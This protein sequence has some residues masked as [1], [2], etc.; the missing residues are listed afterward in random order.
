MGKNLDKLGKI[1]EFQAPWETATGESEVEKPKLRRWI[2]GLLKDKASAQDARDEA[3]EKVKEIETERD[4]VKKE[5]EAKGDP[6]LAKE[7]EKSRGETAKEK[8]R[9]D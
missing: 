2:F 9:A 3:L 1:D 4:E 6:D 8:E 7:L 5:L